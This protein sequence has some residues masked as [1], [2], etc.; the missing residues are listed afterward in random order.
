MIGSGSYANVY[1][2]QDP[3]YGI[4]FAV[5]K[6]KKDLRDEELKRFEKEYTEMRK[7][8][9]HDIVQVYRYMEGENAYFMEYMDMTL[10]EYID[11]NNSKLEMQTRKRICYQILSGFDYLHGK[12]IYHRDISLSNVLVKKYDDVDIFKIADFGLVKTPNSQ[13]TKTEQYQTTFK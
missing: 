5:K 4:K 3:D 2:I 10:K 1:Q 7:L 11:K 12:E 8:S 6:A 9:P 13:M